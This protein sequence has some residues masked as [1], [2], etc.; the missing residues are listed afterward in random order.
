MDKKCILLA[1]DYQVGKSTLAKKLVNVIP[2]SINLSFAN[3]IRERLHIR[4][5]IDK[6]LLYSK[7]T[8]QYIRDLI[9]GYGEYV[10]IHSGINVWSNLL[11]KDFLSTKKEILIIDDFRFIEEHLFFNTVFQKNVIIIYIGEKSNAYDLTEIYE[12]SDIYL[13][14]Y[15]NIEDFNYDRFS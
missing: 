11:Y 10:K 12:M 5:G 4:L 7:P 1:G 6:D 9:K 14:K 13:P 3:E 2:N 15:P 8:P